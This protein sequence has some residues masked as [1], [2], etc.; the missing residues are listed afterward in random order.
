MQVHVVAIG[1]VRL[2]RAESALHVLHLSLHRFFLCFK[3][4]VCWEWHVLRPELK[5]MHGM[6][7]IH[8]TMRIN[9]QRGLCTVHGMWL[10]CTACAACLL[11]GGQAVAVMVMLGKS[12]K[13]EVLGWSSRD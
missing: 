3:Q 7:K 1:C 4:G 12:Y 9:F 13:A 2:V 6:L 10:L 11:G 5:A 8:S